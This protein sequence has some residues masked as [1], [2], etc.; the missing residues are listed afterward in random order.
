MATILLVVPLKTS[1]MVLNLLHDTAANKT[2]NG[3][4]E[5]FAMEGPMV[6][7]LMPFKPNSLELDEAAFV[8]YLD[9]SACCSDLVG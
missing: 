4:A 7:L 8:K 3:T 9:V 1:R 5:A 2:A 6:A